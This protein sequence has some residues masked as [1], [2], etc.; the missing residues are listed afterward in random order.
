MFDEVRQ[1]NSPP[2]SEPD[3]GRRLKASFDVSLLSQSEIINLMNRC[4]E[5]LPPMVLAEMNLEE[6]LVMQYRT[7][8]ALQ[9]DTLED[10]FVEP[11]KKATVVN[12]C[13]NALAQ[14]VK[15]QTELHTAERFKTIEGLMIKAIKQ[16]P[17]EVMN[18]F[19]DNYERMGLG[20]IRD[21]E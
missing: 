20:E 11:N 12:A 10:N 21:V 8:Q 13:G 6:E 4:R 2:P 15:L 17:V 18:D 3:G 16:L 9:Q 14:I 1:P 7:V 19:L 5:A